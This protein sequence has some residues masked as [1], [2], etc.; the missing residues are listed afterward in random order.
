M[1]EHMEVLTE[2]GSVMAEGFATLIRPTSLIM[3]M[4]G[5]L[6]G[7]VI[8]ILPGLG[9]TVTMALLLPFTYTMDP[10]AALAL[11]LGAFSAVSM[12][13]SIP[14]I[15]LNTPGTGEQAITTLDGYPMTQRGEGARAL[16]AG[17][18]AGALGTVFGVVALTVLIPMVRTIILAVGAPE[19]FALSL[20]GVLAIGV[21]TSESVTRGLLSGLMGLMLA[22]VGYDAIT[23]ALR[24][25]GGSLYL[26]DGF[27]TN[28]LTLGLFAV[29]EMIYLY[30]RGKSVAEAV[31]SVR[32]DAR[33]MYSGILQGLRDTVKHSRTAIQGGLIGSIVGLL[34]GMGGTVAM[35]LSYAGAKGRSEHP[36][37]FGKGAVE[38]VIAAESANNAK[39]GGQ[40]VPTV[41]FGIPGG[42]AMAI[43]IGVLFIVGLPPG[44]EL[45]NENLDMVYYMAW[46]LALAGIVGSA[47]GLIIAPHVARLATVSPG[48]LAPVLIAFS[49]GG[50]IVD[51]RLITGVYVVIIAGI[52]GYWLRILDYS[53]AGI[54]LGFLL[55][56]VVERQLFISINA[57]GPSFV[58]RP[59]TLAIFALMAAVIIRQV[60]RSRRR[61]ST[62]EKVG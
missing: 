46:S 56:P 58:T 26:Y 29:A 19:M 55:G 17:A 41:A 54:T 49:V 15:L 61:S 35:F 34:P 20:L 1:S 27:S 51:S 31:D 10:G 37:M 4:V 25:T 45:M 5:I 39:E 59:L 12:G 52:V 14:A 8:G 13:G 22:T 3:L 33:S 36:E 7:L 11:V 18:G 28:A 2:L 6:L 30:S 32:T 60:V 40:L 23:G 44:P 43:F 42:S 16:A 21:L 57:Y 50:A 24:Y 48:V 38:G 47:I 62:K 53:L 9:G